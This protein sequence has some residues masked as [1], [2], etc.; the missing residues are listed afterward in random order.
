M[1]IVVDDRRG[2]LAEHRLNDSEQRALEFLIS[3]R[4]LMEWK[5]TAGD[6]G[7]VLDLNGNT[8]FKPGTIDG[9]KKA[10]KFLCAVLLPYPRVRA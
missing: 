10:L 9:I 1:T 5:F 7:D 8:V 3:E 6:R 4:F 2:G